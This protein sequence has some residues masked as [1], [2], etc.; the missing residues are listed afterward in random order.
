MLHNLYI[1]DDD[2]AVRASLCR[3]VSRQPDYVVRNFP[4]GEDFLNQFDQLEPGV[5]LLDFHMKGANGIAVLNAIRAISQRFVVMMLTAHG[6]V[7]RSVDAMKAGAFDFIEKPYDSAA[8][9]MCLDL[10]FTEL[11]K[12]STEV[13][14]RDAAVAR[15]ALLTPRETEVIAGLAAGYSNKQIAWTL[16]ISPRTVEVYRANLMVKLNVGSLAEALQ[17][18]FVAEQA[19]AA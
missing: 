15:L 19:S 18:V 11:D 3:L 13:G 5:V 4:S 16:R 17:L 2:E 10:A 1:V 12:L 8:L 7:H 9:M 6:A 14:G